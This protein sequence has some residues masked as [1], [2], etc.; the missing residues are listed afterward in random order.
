MFKWIKWLINF[1]AV[2]V[3]KRAR[4]KL[5]AIE[6]THVITAKMNTK[7]TNKELAEMF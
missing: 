1:E 3:P 5:T 4:K 7:A 6:K 2:E